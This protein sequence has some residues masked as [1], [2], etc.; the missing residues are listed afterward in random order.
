MLT[1]LFRK[2]A[3][4]GTKLPAFVRAFST[5]GAPNAL[6]S[7]QDKAAPI[8]C[9]LIEKIVVNHD[10]FIVRFGLEDPKQTLG[11][12]IGEHIEVVAN[13][14]TVEMPA[15]EKVARKYTPVSRVDQKG[16]FDLLI[17]AYRAN[18]KYPTG[19][20]ISQ[21]LDKLKVGDSISINGPT[22]HF[23]YL[24]NGRVLLKA[25]ASKKQALAGG[26]MKNLDKVFKNI[27]FI[28]GGTGITPGYQ[29]IQHILSDPN[30]KTNLYMLYGNKTESDMLLRKEL[31]AIAATGRLKL[32]YT[33]DLP[34]E[35]WKGLTG[36]LTEDMLRS[37]FPPPSDDTLM[38]HCG[39]G[40]MNRLA[41]TLLKNMGYNPEY[42][43]KF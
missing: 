42:Q 17:K 34:P 33:L 9:P 11:L 13:L 31:D 10:T 25:S 21:Y 5:T 30:D 6:G 23:N 20:I 28:A 40:P 36:Y 19:G 37:I 35:G 4:T 1:S 15:G 26:R 22:G 27:C 12:N 32:Y 3:T 29:V 43:F 18:P 2:A 41:T 7:R 24:G 39:P 16:S 14:P 8:V 38:T